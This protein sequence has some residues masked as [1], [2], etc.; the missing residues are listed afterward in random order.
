MISRM[1]LFLLLISLHCA[2]AAPF[3]LAGLNFQFP[4]TWQSQPPSSSMRQGQWSVAPIR[5]GQDAGELTAFFFGT[6]QGGDV[7]SNI[8]RWL[9]SL[10][11]PDGSPVTGETTTR[12]VGGIAITQVEAYGTFASGMPGQPATPK[13]AYGLLGAILEGPQGRVF[14]KLTGPAELVRSQREPFTKAIDSVKR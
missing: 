8:N 7:P 6:G 4:D 2:L 14:F 1:T 10:T 3:Q 5:P 9:R 13:P 11:Q 12:V